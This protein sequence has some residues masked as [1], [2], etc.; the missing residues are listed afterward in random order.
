MSLMAEMDAIERNKWIEHPEHLR[1][2]HKTLNIHWLNKEIDKTEN[3]IR[4]LEEWKAKWELV[5]AHEIGIWE[6]HLRVVWEMQKEVDWI[7]RKH[8]S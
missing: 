3:H 2:H 8:W 4:K 1:N 7:I 5:R 6:L